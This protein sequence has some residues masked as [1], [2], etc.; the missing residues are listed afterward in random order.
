MPRD[1]RSYLPRL[2]DAFATA[3]RPARRVA[4]I[5]RSL[6]D[7]VD[8]FLD[9]RTVRAH[10]SDAHDEQLRPLQARLLRAHTAT[11]AVCGPVDRSLHETID[12]LRD[13]RT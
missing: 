1:V 4:W 7:T 2:R 12:L 8:Y 11:C 9:C 6:H 3:L 10:L 5:D 13:L